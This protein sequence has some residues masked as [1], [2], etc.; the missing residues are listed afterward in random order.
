MKAIVHIGVGWFFMMS[1]CGANAESDAI[2]AEYTAA[3]AAAL[4]AALPGPSAIPIL[5][6]ATLALPAGDKFIPAAVAIRLL[7]SRGQPVNEKTF[8]GM[9]IPDGMH[10]NWA[11]FLNFYKDGYVRDDD[12]K[13]WNADDLLRQLS[14][15]TVRSNPERKAHGAPELAVLGWEE[16][17]TYDV[18]THRMVW[19]TV[20]RK[21][22]DPDDSVHRIANYQTVALGRDGHL[23]LTLASSLATFADDKTIA[24]DL[25]QDVDFKPGKRYADF[26]KFTDHV[27]EYGLAALVLGVTAKKLGLLAIVLAFLAKFSKLGVLIALV[28]A[29]IRK[30]FG[31][32]AATPRDS[33]RRKPD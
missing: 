10:G 17:P 6:E 31:M 14:E 8:V 7:K 30:R 3:V 28:G 1:A 5:D 4:K 12:A 26:D 2:K 33:S 25:L 15:S 13:K 11:G 29:G 22:S 27:A 9:V 32:R 23:D 19:G 24:N 18:A 20:V 21:L 16:A